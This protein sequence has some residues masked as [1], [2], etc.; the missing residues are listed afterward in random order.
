MAD[1][2]SDKLKM[3]EQENG[4]LVPVAQKG[5]DGY[6]PNIRSYCP[7]IT[8]SLK[9]PLLTAQEKYYGPFFKLQ[10]AYARNEVIRFKGS[11]GGVL[12]AIACALLSQGKVKGVLQV[13]SSKDNPTKTVYC[14]SKTVTEIL[15]NAG[16]R[17]APS[18]L[19]ENL[20]TILEQYGPIA[21]VGKPCDIAGVKQFLDTYPEFA[22]KVY[23]T[24]SFM[25]M[26]LPSQNATNR[27]IARLGVEHPR[28]VKELAYRG[29]GWPGNASVIANN[30]KRYACS[31]NDSWGKILGKDVL[32]RCKICP[33]GWGS[34]ADISVG[35]AWYTDGK[36][37]I[38]DERPGRNLLFTRTKRGCSVLADV[39]DEIITHKYNIAELAIIQKSQHARKDRLWASYIVLK[40][41]GD[42]ILNFRG[43]GMW[44]CIMKNSPWQ[45]VRMM[46]GFVRRLPR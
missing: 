33:D 38:F 17:Y 18:S 42:R 11:S 12:T 3:V 31:Y 26:G 14:F 29:N 28:Y 9:N 1:I 30:Q 25:C 43:L 10:V 46:L 19:L 41:S 37:P 15:S 16:S 45:T 21:V 32:F 39:G 24:L 20:R 44:S 4:F 13:C 2:G 23:C 22:E 7:G 27:L 8:V 40:L 6:V 5:F 36:K 35:D 34:F